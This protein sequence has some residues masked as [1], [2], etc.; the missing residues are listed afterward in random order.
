M[1][2]Y[3]DFDAISVIVLEEEVQNLF[4]GVNGGSIYK[5]DNYKRVKD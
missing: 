3:K 5:N 1:K 4:D 2:F